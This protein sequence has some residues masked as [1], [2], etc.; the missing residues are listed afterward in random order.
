[1]PHID[2]LALLI[3]V[4]PL[5]FA[6]TVHEFAHAW[7]ALKCGDPTARDMGR[8]TLNPIVH[9]DPLGALCLLFAPF[10]WA[11]PVP[12][13]PRNFRRPRRDD[14]LVSVAGVT[15]NLLTACVVAMV[16]RGILATGFHPLA[17]GVSPAGRTLWLM[18]ELL[19]LISVGLM[20][21]NL[22]PIPPLDG[23]HVLANLLPPD[24][25]LGYR[26]MAPLAGIVLVVLVLS[27]AFGVIFW[28]LLKVIA[29][30]LLGSAW[31]ITGPAG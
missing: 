26:R 19:C 2:P 21:F 31:I 25:A 5:L 29:G 11:R 22:V 20:I 16:L 9:L 8:L 12:V 15:A 1:M 10:G 24:L 17:L 18:G 7:A 4:P 28:P 23:S 3:R 14:I 6:L 30:T 13:D 27:G